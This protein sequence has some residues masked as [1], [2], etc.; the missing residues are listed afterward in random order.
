[1]T[2][3]YRFSTKN[4]RSLTNIK[5]RHP[6]SSYG[7][8]KL[9]SPNRS[10]IMTPNQMIDE[11]RRI[12]EYNLTVAK[13]NMT[14]LLVQ[15]QIQER[16][17]VADALGDLANEFKKEPSV[18]VIMFLFVFV[19]GLVALCLF[20]FHNGFN[21]IGFGLIAATVIG[22]FISKSSYKTSTIIK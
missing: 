15:K 1:M 8:I 3:L 21:M 2:R 13:H 17:K 20:S 16:Q 19:L 4:T 11:D 12:E 6:L 10:M 5:N 14:I 22:V 18:A 7:I 9:N